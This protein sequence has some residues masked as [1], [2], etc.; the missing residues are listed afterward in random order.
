MTGWFLTLW[1]SWFRRIPPEQRRA[2]AQQRAKGRALARIVL[3]EEPE[4]KVRMLTPAD[5]VR[6]DRDRKGGDR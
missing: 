6:A 4:S 3:D 5:F 1:R 2:T